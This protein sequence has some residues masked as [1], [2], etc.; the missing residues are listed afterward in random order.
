MIF[1]ANKSPKQTA[2]NPIITIKNEFKKNDLINPWLINWNNL[3]AQPL[4]VVRDPQKPNP[5]I[6]LFLLEIGN[7][8]IRPNKK[9]PI[10]F[11][12]N[13]SSIC[14]RKIAPGIAPTEMKRILF[15]SKKLLIY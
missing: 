6:N 4:N 11:T 14:H 10:V 3:K 8:F 2:K 13:I 9:Q 5:K 7:A 12:I 1:L 15:L